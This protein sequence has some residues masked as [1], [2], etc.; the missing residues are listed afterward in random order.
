LDS[1]E[2]D[3]TEI[4]RELSKE[5]IENNFQDYIQ[6][7]LPAGSVE[8][9][10]TKY[11]DVIFQ[12]VSET[13]MDTDENIITIHI[14]NDEDESQNNSNNNQDEDEMEVEER[15]DDLQVA[16]ITPQASNNNNNNAN[17]DNNDTTNNN[18]N[19]DD[20]YFENLQKKTWER[21]E[22]G[23]WM[24]TKKKSRL[25][26]LLGMEDKELKLMISHTRYKVQYLIHNF[27]CVYIIRI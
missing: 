25:S 13:E 23:E 5:E 20:E 24:S 11:P 16:L 17:N 27:I 8:V 14:Q 22:D 7:L 21:R 3:K 1:D 4:K 6:S 12:P 9:M 2:S 15:N 26:F 18:T 19:K 10:K